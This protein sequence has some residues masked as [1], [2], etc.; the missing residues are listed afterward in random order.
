MIKLPFN[1][2]ELNINFFFKK[3]SFVINFIFSNLQINL[4]INSLCY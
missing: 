4:N 1:L 2:I 3:K